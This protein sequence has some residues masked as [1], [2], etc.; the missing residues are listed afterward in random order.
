MSHLRKN[1]W[2]TIRQA[3]EGIGGR[4]SEDAYQM[5]LYAPH[6]GKFAYNKHNKFVVNK[7][8][9]TLDSVKRML[10]SGLIIVTEHHELIEFK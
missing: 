5:S 1:D 4:V 9:D 6:H 8:H 7:R 3:I 10:S 2:T